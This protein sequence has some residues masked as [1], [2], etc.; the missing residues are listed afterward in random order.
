MFGTDTFELPLETLLL[1]SMLAEST[2]DDLEQTLMSLE[3]EISARRAFQLRLLSE[4]DRR[5][6]AQADACKSLVDWT[7]SRLDVERSTA[8][9]LVVSARTVTD[10]IADSLA[11]GL[12]TLDRATATARLAATGVDDA[13]ETGSRYD[14]SGVRR[15]AAARREHTTEDERDLFKDRYYAAQPNLANTGGRF[16]G[17]L[18]GIAWTTLDT[19]I[20]SRADQLPKLPDGTSDTFRHRLADAL[21]SIAEDSLGATNNGD[22]PVH[23]VTVFVDSNGATVEGGVRIGPNT[24]D[25]LLCAAPVEIVKINTPDGVPRVARSARRAIPAPTRRFVLARDQVCTADGC[26]STY[27]LQPHHVGEFNKTQNH[28]PDN[29]TSMCW[30][31]HHVVIHQQGYT[32]D[33]NSPPHRRRFTPPPD[34]PRRE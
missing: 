22:T 10:E 2:N 19:A 27:R 18:A 15:L 13:L 3:S 17:H 12:I 5:Q 32:I 9:Q 25:A 30:F 21:T 6:A 4:L 1:T 23:R 16:W 20:R 11:L 8:S 34:A 14:V 28:H 33:E 31:H 26:D 7:M 29:L 24:L